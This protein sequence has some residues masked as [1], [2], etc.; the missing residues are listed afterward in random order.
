MP[1]LRIA[2]RLNS[3]HV[4]ETLG[5]CMLQHGVWGFSFAQDTTSSGSSLPY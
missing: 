4:I 2:R 5:D 1:A 3:Y